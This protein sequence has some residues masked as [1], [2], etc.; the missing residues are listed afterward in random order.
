[1]AAV[2]SEGQ[3]AWSEAGEG[4]TNAAPAFA[5]DAFER[6]VAENAPA[7]EP[8]GEPVVAADADGD[9]VAYGF[10]AGGDEGSFEIDGET[11]QIAVAGGAALDY[12]SGEVVYTVTVEASDGALADTAAVTIRITDVPPPG[13]P[14][15]PVVTGGTEALEVAWAAPAN[16]GPEI[17]G[18]DLRYRDEDAQDWIERALGNVLSHTIDGPLEEG[19]T[20]EAQ[21]RAKSTEGEGAW[22]GS[23]ALTTGRINDSPVFDPDVVERA[24]AENAAAGEPVAAADAD[25][26]TLAYRFV[27]GGDEGSFEI[28]AGTGQITVAEGAVLDYE[29][30]DTLY[31]VRVEA[32][33]GEL[34]D[35]A[36]VTIRV[37][38]EPAPGRP[39]RPIVTRARN[40]VLAKWT[41]PA[42]EGPPITRYDLRYRIRD[43]EQDWSVVAIHFQGGPTIASVISNTL[44]ATTYEVQVRAVN[45]EGEGAWSESGEGTTNGPPAFGAE[46]FGRSVA[47]NTAAGGPVGDPVAAEDADDDMLT[48]GFVAGGDEE[49]FAID[50]STGRIT[51]GEGTELDYESGDTVYAVTVEASD[52]ALADTAAVTI[53]VTDEP[54]PGKPEM[55]VV[56]GG[57]RSLVVAWA[58]PENAGPEITGY[59]VRHRETGA[60][61]WADSVP[62]GDVLADTIAGLADA[63]VYEV[64]VRAQSAEGRGPWSDSGEGTTTGANRPPAFSADAVDRVVA[65]NTAAGDTVG[66]PV[67]AMDPDGDTVAYR[68]VPGGDEGSFAIHPVTGQITVG[69]GPALN[70]ESADSVSVVRVEASDGA[71]SDTATVTIRLTDADDP[72]TVTLSPDAAR[73]G[74]R[75]TA[76]LMDQDGSEEGSKS[77]QWQRSEAADTSWTDIA[78]A[79][80]RFYT[81]VAGDLGKLL[82]WLIAYEDGHGPGK[83]AVSAALPV[84]ESQ[85]PAF[86]SAAFERSV[87][88]NSAAG[89][90][91]GDPVT[92]SGGGQALSYAFVPGEDE[93]LFE[94]AAGTGQ[95]TVADGAALDYEGDNTLAVSVEASDGA[96][97]DTA[98]VTIRLTNEDDPGTVT[99]NRSVARVGVS[100]KATLMDEDGSR[101]QG[102]RR[103]WQR[104][105]D[106]A[107]TVWTD[108]AGA[109]KQSYTPAA[110][111][112]GM[113]L[114][115]RITYADGHGPG[116]EALSAV[117]KVLG[118]ATP[119]VSF[120]A[121]GYTVPVG[122]SVDVAVKLSPAQ[123]DTLAVDVTVGG[124]AEPATRTVTFPPGDTL[125][126]LEV[127]AAGLAV[128]DTVALAF[129]D[130][131]EGTVAGVPAEAEV[132]VTE[133]DGSSAGDADGAAAL[134]VEYAEPAYTAAAGGAGT[135]VTVRIAPAADREVLVPVTVTGADGGTREHAAYGIARSVRFEPNDSLATFTV[136]AP[137]GAPDG[138]L[139]LAFGALPDGVAAGPAAT[140]VL[141]VTGADA[142]SALLQ[143][144]LDVGLAVFGRAVAEGA[145]QAVGGRIDA[146]MRPGAAD[147]TAPDGRGRSPGEW[148][149]RALGGVA[150]LTGAP[151]G[152][153]AA[154]TRDIALPTGREAAQRLLPQISFSAPSAAGGRPLRPGSACGA[155]AR[156]RGSGASPAASPTTAA[157]ARSPSAPTRASDPRRSPAWRSCAATGTSTIPTVRSKAR[158]ATP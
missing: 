128:S 141:S 106:V 133:A 33:D 25:A 1:M 24:V 89:E 55:P 124:S 31:A 87:P 149:A 107:D 151:L 39:E 44:P 99:L 81:P 79:T 32:S 23:G 12:E 11:G 82:R 142:R 90:P 69:D 29:S 80:G 30:G 152:G 65:E 95:I 103:R 143:Q 83:R 17:A 111:D 113:L 48:Y 34:A 21:V 7:G 109:T 66:A 6:T 92:A 70:Y 36:E 116:K 126:A 115:W 156:C 102:K 150:A 10:V 9:T 57:E 120:G 18:Y 137:A 72:G 105:P 74:V 123:A 68:F 77:R 76:T 130:L 155:R 8:V 53:R 85:A 35:T 112:E 41:A 125:A 19:T 91:V 5:A 13:R 47:E 94:I 58:A 147:A 122:G 46:T 117:L 144:S 86:D 129:A 37:T 138:T 22:S 148:A 108:I 49:V 59:D 93:T 4:T 52:G 140:A 96:L 61:A 63:T 100:I 118:A 158:S 67:G 27:A 60:P 2:S 131:P 26:D 119:V 56:T 114:R 20:Y 40:G 139:A 71:L 110:G 16:D 28:G 15:A 121:A 153:T 97:A 50:G 132:V 42:N 98:A 88:E 43:A 45:A 51:V 64:Q 136:E 62:V 54:A 75:L 135:E 73:V 104:S 78:G 101:N 38:D 145:R 146:A 134:A 3:S 157:C 127:S 154:P 84:T 14:D